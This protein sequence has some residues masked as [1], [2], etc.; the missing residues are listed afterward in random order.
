MNTPEYGDY[1][2]IRALLAE[3]DTY[4]NNYIAEHSG[5]LRIHLKAFSGYNRQTEK[6]REWARV[7]SEFYDL[8]YFIDSLKAARAESVASGTGRSGTQ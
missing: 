1:T 7:V 2:E 5:Y 6:D 4:Q 3:C 8:R